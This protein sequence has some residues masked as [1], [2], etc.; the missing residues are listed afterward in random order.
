[1][2]G[3][4]ERPRVSVVIPTFQRRAALQ[5]LLGALGRQTLSAELFEVVV[6]IDG[7]RDG[8]RE[9]LVSFRAPY[10]LRSIWQPNGGRAVACNSAIRLAEG[11]LVVILDDDMEPAPG[12]LEAH[13]HEHPSGARRCVMGAVPITLEDGDPPHVRYVA[14]KFNQHLARLARPDHSFQ[15]RDFYSGN[16]SVRREELMAAG[17]FDERFREYG[18]EDLELAHRLVAGGME[19]GFSI[20]AVARQHYDK[21]LRRLASDELAKG[22]TAVLF[23][24]THPEASLELKITALGAQRVRRR[25]ARRAVLWAT[26]VFSR[27]PDLVLAAVGVAQRLAPNRMQTV[28]RFALEYFYALGVERALHERRELPP[29]AARAG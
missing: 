7:S 3:N 18:N 9:A 16:S 17:L 13:Q 28:Y 8:T 21:T 6:G 24:A 4:S 15:I 11:D 22:R 2:T 1:M 12:L 26:R 5:R 27:M 23:A 14:E 20:D 19:L 25:A 10:R 29:T